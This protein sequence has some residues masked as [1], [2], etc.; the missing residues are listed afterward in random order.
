MSIENTLYSNFKPYQAYTT[1]ANKNKTSKKINIKPLIGAAVGVAAATLAT[2]KI[3]KKP[4]F[5][6][7]KD[8]PVSTFQDVTEL[9]M[10]AGCANIGGVI[11]GSIGKDSNQ[12]KKKIHEAGF[13]IMNTSIPML[14]VTAA[15][16]ICES[17]KQLNKTPIKII[18][19]FAAMATGAIMATKITNFGK[20]KSQKRK[21]TIKDSLANF[22]DI[23]ATIKI[24]FRRITD[25]VPVDK[26]LPFIYIY[27]GYRAGNK[28]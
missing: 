11:G 20:E 15:L 16:K 21:Y 19:S 12:I 8:L 25:I 6:N 22:D 3:F 27:N 28:E 7:N 24:G 10:M 23:I 1:E 13:Q 18:S 26:I 4:I 14:M 2:S 9:L 17:S 5:G